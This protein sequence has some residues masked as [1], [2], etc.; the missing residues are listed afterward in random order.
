M[1][2][3]CRLPLRRSLFRARWLQTNCRTSYCDRL[4]FRAQGPTGEATQVEDGEFLPLA[5]AEIIVQGPSVVLQMLAMSLKRTHDLVASRA[6][7]R[8][9]AKIA[10]ASV[11]VDIAPE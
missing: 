4:R 3:F 7:G 2:S 10:A 1:V 8:E 11:I 5:P 6:S 9:P